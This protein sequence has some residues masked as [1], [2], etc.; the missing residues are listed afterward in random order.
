MSW[1]LA[2]TMLASIVSK[3]SHAGHAI[4]QAPAQMPA[5]SL[6]PTQPIAPRA[7]AGLPPAQS[8]APRPGAMLSPAEA[9]HPVS[10]GPTAAAMPAEGFSGAGQS[11]SA[12]RSVSML[13]P[14]EAP[15]PVAG[16]PSGAAISGAPQNA[17]ATASLNAPGNAST[18]GNTSSGSAPPNLLAQV[19]SSRP[20]PDAVTLCM[21]MERPCAQLP[22][23][24][25]AFSMHRACLNK[26]A[27]EESRP[28]C[29]SPGAIS[30]LAPS[31]SQQHQHRRQQYLLP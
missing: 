9:P 14:R 6:P 17:S 19:G 4:A 8:I 22:L 27:S 13:P 29:R 16:A 30:P 20:E 23:P 1:V 2:E 28:P 31:S 15:H 12:P 10:G 7:S 11:A 26:S 18:S 24:G 21:V 5:A 3:D 25:Y